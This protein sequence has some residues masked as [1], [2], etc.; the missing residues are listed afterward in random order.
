MFQPI[1][2]KIIFTVLCIYTSWRWSCNGWNVQ[3]LLDII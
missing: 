1:K 3:L 2:S